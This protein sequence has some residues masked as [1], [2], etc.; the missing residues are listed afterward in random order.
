[1]R[2]FVIIVVIFMLVIV[3]YFCHNE[4]YLRSCC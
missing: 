3:V 4:L 1:V 2:V